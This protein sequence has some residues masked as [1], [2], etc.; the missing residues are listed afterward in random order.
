MLKAYT[1]YSFCLI[2]PSSLTVH[3][4]KTSCLEFCK[5]IFHKQTSR[6]NTF[7]PYWLTHM[8]KEGSAFKIWHQSPLAPLQPIIEPY[9][10]IGLF[11]EHSS[12]FMPPDSRT[13][14]HVCLWYLSW[15]SSFRKSY[16]SF[17]RNPNV[18]SSLKLSSFLPPSMMFL[19]SL[20]HLGHI[21]ITKLML[22]L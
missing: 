10:I 1:S 8:I 19:Y 15:L 21:F 6:T 7:F 4:K 22:Y 2:V 13:W 20:Q 9:Q 5:I 17:R 14:H 11:P 3:W 12:P 16:I 18:D